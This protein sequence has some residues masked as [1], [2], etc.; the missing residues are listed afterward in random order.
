MPAEQSV[1]CE[2]VLDLRLQS[3]TNLESFLFLEGFFHL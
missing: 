3:L 1:L 2:M